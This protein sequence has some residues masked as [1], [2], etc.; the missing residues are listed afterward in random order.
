MKLTKLHR[1]WSDRKQNN[2]PFSI[3]PPN[4]FFFFFTKWNNFSSSPK[5]FTWQ[6]VGKLD[7]FALHLFSIFIHT[8]H[9]V[10]VAMR[11]NSPQHNSMKMFSTHQ[12]TVWN[13]VGLIAVCT[14]TTN[15][16]FGSVKELWSGYKFLFY[17][18]IKAPFICQKGLKKGNG[19]VFTNF[20]CH[21]KT[22]SN[23][24]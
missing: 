11:Y 13:H 1:G 18:L 6:T 8:K 9:S 23:S 17:I 14:N 15:C 19:H 12:K 16:C 21:H 22:H 10:V 7:K 4:F 24:H 2:V 5:S 20:S 3:L